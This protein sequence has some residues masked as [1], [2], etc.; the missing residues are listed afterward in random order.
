MKLPKL[1]LPA[2]IDRVPPKR[3]HSLQF[4]TVPSR[5][6]QKRER[7][8]QP[9]VK[10]IVIKSLGQGFFSPFTASQAHQPIF[11]Q[12]LEESLFSLGRMSGDFIT[13]AP[14][15]PRSPQ[16]HRTNR[17]SQKKHLPANSPAKIYD[18]LFE[19][20]QFVSNGAIDLSSNTVGY[21]TPAN[22]IGKQNQLIAPEQ[23]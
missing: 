22:T 20:S 6:N 8:H 10:Q 11:R 14:T 15:Q 18:Q 19:T 23:S 3:T 13:I 1:F 9:G 2:R 12:L 21:G 4:S 7:S 16:S 17:Q 5:S